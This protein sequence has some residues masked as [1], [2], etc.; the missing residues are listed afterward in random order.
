[1]S[2]W[3]TPLVVTTSDTILGLMSNA[4]RAVY[5]LPAIVNSAI[6]FDEIHAFDD[7]FDAR[8]RHVAGRRGAVAQ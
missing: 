3:S 5:S 1:L 6:V 4:R 2:L 7:Q 8:R